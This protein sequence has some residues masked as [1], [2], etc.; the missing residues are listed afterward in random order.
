MIFHDTDSRED[1][2]GME[3]GLH[4]ESDEGLPDDFDGACDSKVSNDAAA[5]QVK[6]NAEIK[7]EQPGSIDAKPLNA[8]FMPVVPSVSNSMMSH[9]S[10]VNELSGSIG[11]AR[12]SS[13]K[14]QG[15]VSG[16]AEL[17]K[18]PDCFS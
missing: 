16:V 11:T 9:L 8:E 12:A 7:P 6:E 15:M 10:A 13:D 17:Q 3:H 5:E 18:I 14:F 1:D 4:E 2:K